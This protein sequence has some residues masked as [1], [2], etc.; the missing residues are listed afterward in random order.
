MGAS[1]PSNTAIHR[2]PLLFSHANFRV[3]V[4]GM[5]KTIPPGPS[6]LPQKINERKTTSVDRPSL[7]PHEPRFNHIVEYEVSREPHTG[8]LSQ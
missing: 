1:G 8:N 4:S 7:C 2:V 3:M 5:H 6:R